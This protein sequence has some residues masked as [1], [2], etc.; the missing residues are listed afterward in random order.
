VSDPARSSA[1]ERVRRSVGRQLRNALVALA[2]LA[3]LGTWIWRGWSFTLRPG[4]AAVLLLLG[5]HVETITQEGFHVRLPAPFLE[6]HVVR[7]RELRTE[8]FGLHAGAGEE[9]PAEL[10]EA[11]MQ[12]SDNN[13]VRV[14]FTVQYTVKDPFEASFHLEDPAGVVRDAAQAAMREVVGRTTVDGVLREEKALV[15]AEAARR[16]QEILDAYGAGLDVGSLQL[17]DVQPPAEVRAAFDDVVAANQ[18]ASRLVNEAE[19]HR[20]EVVPKARA[21]AAEALAQA[22][23]YRESKVAEATGAASRFRAIAAEYR[24]APEVTRERL[25]LETM[26]EVL[27]RVEKVIVE[28]GAASLVPTLPLGRGREPRP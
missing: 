24:L 12:T 14:S 22:Q 8:D 27:P 5:R 23:G 11:T 16:L 4:E 2:L 21:E 13:I 19:G 7:V 26:E 25:Y 17:Q 18:D 20:N 10:H 28:P 9:T 1:D 3:A 6:R 15:T